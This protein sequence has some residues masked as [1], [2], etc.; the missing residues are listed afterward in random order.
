VLKWFAAYYVPGTLTGGLDVW[1]TERAFNADFTALRAG[2]TLYASTPSSFLVVMNP[3]RHYRVCWNGA[4]IPACVL[5]SG[6]LNITLPAGVA[7]GRLE[8]APTEAA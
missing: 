8:I 4:E 7:E 5:P 1:I 2:L 3:S 6:A